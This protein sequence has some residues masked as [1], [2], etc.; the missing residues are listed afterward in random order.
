[1]IRI[2]RNRGYLCALQTALQWFHNYLYMIVELVSYLSPKRT[3]GISRYAHELYK[4]LNR[5]IS[6]RLTQSNFL[7]FSNRFR[8][9]SNFP[10]GI[11]NHHSGSI[12]HFTQIQGCAQMLWRPVHPALATVHDLGFFLCKEDQALLNPLERKIVNLHFS[13]LKKLDLIVAVSEFTR[14]TILSQLNCDPQKVITV[15]SGINIQYIHSIL[16]KNNSLISSH[17]RLGE[18]P[19][20]W[21]LYVGSELPRKNINGLLNIVAEV[22]N[23]VP[24]V[25]LIKIGSSGGARFR[26]QTLE[27]IRQLGL[28]DQVLFF[29]DITDEELFQFYK[30]ADILVHPSILEGFCFPVL[31]AFACELPVICSN[32]GSLPEITAQAAIMHCPNDLQSF[33]SSI[34]NILGNNYLREHIVSQGKIRASQFSWEITADTMMAMY[35]Q[36]AKVQRA[37][38]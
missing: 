23:Y 38:G 10:I 20:P 15:H 12:V 29:D 28:T 35:R 4:Q 5:Q 26:G 2:I 22:R 6:V 21:L 9:L 1:M 3:T 24:E 27:K 14:Q 33:V 13:G 8:F 7:P 16:A 31:E 18:I 30:E 32:S 34:L 11:D 17:T 25:H 19:H 36:V 37:N